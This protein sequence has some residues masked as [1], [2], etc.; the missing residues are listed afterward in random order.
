MVSEMDAVWW[1]SGSIQIIV[2]INCWLYRGRCCCLSM[3][4][5]C[6]GDGDGVVFAADANTHRPL[7]H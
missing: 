7:L 2:R 5:G 6:G 1:L 4:S 3:S